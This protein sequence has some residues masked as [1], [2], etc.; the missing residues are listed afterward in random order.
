MRRLYRFL[1]VLFLAGG[2]FVSL[3]CGNSECVDD[4]ND[5]YGDNCAGGIDC[6]DNEPTIF[7]DAPELCDG[8]DNQCPGNAG[9]GE[10]DENCP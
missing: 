5:G 8:I 7:Q 3:S 4:D 6:N 10:V 9:Y 2:M 1:A